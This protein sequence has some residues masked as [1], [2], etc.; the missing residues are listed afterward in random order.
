MCHRYTFRLKGVLA[1]IK[2]IYRWTA[3]RDVTFSVPSGAM[4]GWNMNPHVRLVCIRKSI[5]RLKQYAG[6]AEQL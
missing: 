5:Y 4:T 1:S 6:F 2:H 3:Q